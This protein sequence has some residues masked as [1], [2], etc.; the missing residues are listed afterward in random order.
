MDICARG[1][2]INEV[3]ASLKILLGSLS[4]IQVTHTVQLFTASHGDGYGGCKGYA[5]SS[6]RQ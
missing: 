1:R 4:G 3:C 5:N 6:A 2:R